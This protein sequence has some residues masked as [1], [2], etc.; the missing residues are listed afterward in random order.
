MISIASKPRRAWDCV[1]NTENMLKCFATNTQAERHEKENKA[2]L[3]VIFPGRFS[4]AQLACPKR[5]SRSRGIQ[6]A[7][8]ARQMTLAASQNESINLHREN[9]LAVKAEK[10]KSS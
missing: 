4:S 8:Q 5:K 1:E 2:K 9:R 10:G 6:R 3:K 7:D